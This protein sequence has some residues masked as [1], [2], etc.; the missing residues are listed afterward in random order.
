MTYPLPATIVIDHET[1]PLTPNTPHES[2]DDI[3]ASP[4]SMFRASRVTPAHWQLHVWLTDG[5]SIDIDLFS[6]HPIGASY[7]ITECS[8]RTCGQPASEHNY[9]ARPAG[10]TGWS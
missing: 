7:Q 1:R 5:R 6:T 10:C 2:I 9:G 8:C 4:A 3:V